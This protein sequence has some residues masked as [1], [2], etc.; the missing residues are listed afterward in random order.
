MAKD[1]DIVRRL[2]SRTISVS[3]RPRKPTSVGNG[4]KSS[5]NDNQDPV[6][7]GNP[8]ASST[9]TIITPKN[10]LTDSIFGRAMT[11][12]DQLAKMTSFFMV[13]FMK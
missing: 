13:R 2:R 11:A 1:K 10:R 9:K 5:Q 8:S 6:R 12:T 3:D 7:M 4:K